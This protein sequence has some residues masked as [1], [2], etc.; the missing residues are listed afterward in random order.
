MT[1]NDFVLFKIRIPPD[2]MNSENC[3]ISQ[4]EIQENHKLSHKQ[5]KIPLFGGIYNSRLKAKILTEMMIKQY[6]IIAYYI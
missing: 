1:R 3:K 5:G 6:F 4:K 2:S